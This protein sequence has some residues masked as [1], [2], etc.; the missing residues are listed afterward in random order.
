MMGGKAAGR[1]VRQP[2]KNHTQ[3]GFEYLILGLFLLT[4]S[5]LLVVWIFN[6]LFNSN[7]GKLDFVLIS[8][9]SPYLA[10]YSADLRGSIFAVAPLDLGIIK[11]ILQDQQHANEADTIIDQ[12]QN[13]VSTVTPYPNQSGIGQFTATPTQL[14]S[15]LTSTIA[16]SATVTRTTTVTITPTPS[17]TVSIALPTATRTSVNVGATATPTRFLSPTA[18]VNLPT[19]TPISATATPIPSTATRIPPTATRVNPTATSGGYPAPTQGAASPT[20]APTTPAYP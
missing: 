1:V 20:P 15:V 14:P 3:K 6:P 12:Y 9:H 16:I 13:I 4:L 7:R 10:D 8:L 18:S 17:R 11:E 2:P 5:G 19:R